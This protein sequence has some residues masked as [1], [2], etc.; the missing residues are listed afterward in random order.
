M[1][2][3]AGEVW[4]GLAKNA[5]EGMASLGRIPVFTAFLFLGQVLP[6][7]LAVLAYFQ[8]HSRP[9]KIAV[10]AMVLGYG[11]RFFSAWRYRQSWRG[12]FLHPLGVLVLLVVQWYALLRKL[13]G[14]PAIW[15][16]RKYQ[17]G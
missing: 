15:K 8:Q 1:Y 9:L 7:P 12:A 16:E 13:F 10:L 11:M 17:L 2:L 6:L 14:R 5:T 4:R 3:G